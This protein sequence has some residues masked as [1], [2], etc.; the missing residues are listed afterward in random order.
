MNFLDLLQTA[1]SNMLKSKVRTLLTIIA[2]F[3]GAMT[4]TLT[5]GIGTGIKSYLNQQVGNLGATNVLSIQLKDKSAPG[6]STASSA[7][8][9]YNPNQKTALAR[10][11][12]RGGGDKVL[13]MTTKD[14][15]SIKSVP[16][17]TSATAVRGISPDYIMGTSGKYQFSVEQQYGATTAAMATGTGVSNSSTQNQISIPGNYV[18]SLGYSSNRAII[19]KTVTIGITS[20]EGNQS[21]TTAVVT[22][23]QQA[24]LIGDSTTFA[25]TALANQLLNIQSTGLPTATADSFSTVEATFPTNLTAAQITTLKNSLSAKGYTGQ[26]IKD[27]ENTIFTAID[28]IIIV[29]D[30]FGVIA[31]LAASFGIVNTLFMSVQERTKEI[32]LMKALGMSPRKIF[33]LFSI[34]AVLI[35]FW[36]SILGVGFAALLGKAIDAVASHGFLKDFTGLSLLTFPLSTIAI[37]VLGIM[38][39]AFL[40][41]TLPALRAS[42]K[43]PIDALRYE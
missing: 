42:R 37:V 36:G 30:M 10:A 7:P 28:A 40:A 6:P 17:V 35:G 20:A 8:T 9:A 5:N 39:I 2:I 33:L 23:V 34:E 1:S 24:N 12:G 38:A 22:G 26:T 41:G 18:S 4:I 3:I 21:I 13:L 14:V 11:G 16:N 29:F 27:T 25:N 19:G 15:N 43:D 32:G 31:L